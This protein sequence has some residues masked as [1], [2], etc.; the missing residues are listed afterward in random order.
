M[1]TLDNGDILANDTIELDFDLCFEYEYAWNG[2]CGCWDYFVKNKN[3]Y[4]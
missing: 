3:T 2:Y 1:T 4:T